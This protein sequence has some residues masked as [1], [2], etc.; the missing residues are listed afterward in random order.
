MSADDLYLISFKLLSIW[1]KWNRNPI[2]IKNLINF[3]TWNE[4]RPVSYRLIGLLNYNPSDVKHQITTFVCNDEIFDESLQVSCIIYYL[5]FHLINTV[6][7][8]EKN[9]LHNYRDYYVTGTFSSPAL[10]ILFRQ[11]WTIKK[12]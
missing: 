12:I 1:Y 5:H 11:T 10:Q 6:V 4:F 8:N 2:L 3:Y 7:G 9:P